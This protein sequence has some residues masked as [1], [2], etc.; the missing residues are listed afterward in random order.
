ML[1]LPYAEEKAELALAV[2]ILVWSCLERA[3]KIDNSERK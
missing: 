3:R 1:S 2:I